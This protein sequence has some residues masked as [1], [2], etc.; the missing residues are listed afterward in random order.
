MVLVCHKHDFIFLKTRKT[1]GTSIEMALEPLCVP[2]GQKIVEFHP[3]QVSEYGIV[4]R[5]GDQY[6]LKGWRKPLRYREWRNHRS[7]A[8][9]RRMIGQK[10]WDRRLKITAVRNPFDRM[11]SYF[12]YMANIFGR[13]QPTGLDETRKAFR[14]FCHGS[15]WEDDRRIVFLDDKF[16]IDRAIRFEHMADDLKQLSTD[17]ELPITPDAMPV[18]K[19]MAK[20]RKKFDVPDYFDA[21]LV[22]LVK[23]RMSWVFDHYDYA[24]APQPKYAPA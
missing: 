16:I 20:V 14:A 10:E 5:R 6:R 9:V 2:P 4:G 17:L 1:A 3:V 21:D 19:S 11:V 7:A 23:T 24:T 13:K 18:T 15:E 12:H 8:F 22:E